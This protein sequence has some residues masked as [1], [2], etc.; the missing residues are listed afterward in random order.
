MLTTGPAGSTAARG[1]GVIGVEAG[2]RPGQGAPLLDALLRQLDRLS[3]VF[4][5]GL[6]RD[7]GDQKRPEG[8]E[9]HGHYQQGDRHLD[10]RDACVAGGRGGLLEIMGTVSTS[11]LRGLRDDQSYA[12]M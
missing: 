5:A 4:V 1:R 10:Q 8:S 9:D 3:A 12:R 6:R 2:E 11:T 7:G